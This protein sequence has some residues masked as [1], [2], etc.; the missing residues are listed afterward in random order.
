MQEDMVK[1]AEWLDKCWDLSP[2]EKRE[3][4]GY[5]ERP[6]KAMNNI[7]IPSGYRN[8]EDAAMTDDA[9]TNAQE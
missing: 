4:K 5:G 3:V 7:Y 2:N 8:I 9:F 1:V 6:E